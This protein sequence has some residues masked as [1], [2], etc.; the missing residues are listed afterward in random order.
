MHDMIPGAVALDESELALI[1]G[2]NGGFWAAVLTAAGIGF[3]AGQWIWCAI[4]CLT[5]DG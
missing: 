5:T 1:A 2:G 3:K 4:E